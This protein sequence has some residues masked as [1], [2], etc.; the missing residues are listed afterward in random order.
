[1]FIAYLRLDSAS[2]RWLLVDEGSVCVPSTDGYYIDG[3]NHGLVVYH[4]GCNDRSYC[5]SA[6]NSYLH[7]GMARVKGSHRYMKYCKYM[8]LTLDLLFYDVDDTAYDC[9]DPR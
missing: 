6:A 8:V 3:R 5:S 4:S 7:N 1:M 2:I 9:D